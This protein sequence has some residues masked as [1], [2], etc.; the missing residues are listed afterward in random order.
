MPRARGMRVAS[1]V[2][3]S[4]SK[5]IA[6]HARKDLDPAGTSV[7]VPETRLDRLERREHESDS[8]DQ[9]LSETFPASDPISPFVPAV[10]SRTVVREVA[11]TVRY[12]NVVIGPWPGSGY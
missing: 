10:P 11:P 8:L 7:L 3:A 6:A 4:R 9:A 12:A 5:P 1:S 2:A